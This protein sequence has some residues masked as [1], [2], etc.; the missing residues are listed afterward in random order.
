MQPVHDQDDRPLLLVIQP[1]I[2]G[3]VEPL[4]GRLPLGL[5]QGLVGLQRVVD[6]DDVGTPS[7][8]H[9]TEVATRLPCWVV[10]NSCTA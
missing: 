2:E 1:A 8:Q 10:S 9:P 4:V 7:G 3:V 5:R 6:D